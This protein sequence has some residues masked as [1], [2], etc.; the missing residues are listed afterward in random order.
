MGSSLLSIAR[1]VSHNLRLYADIVLYNE[2]YHRTTSN[3]K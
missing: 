3:C 2:L 1:M